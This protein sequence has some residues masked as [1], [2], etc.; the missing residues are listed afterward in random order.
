MY[1]AWIQDGLK[2]YLEQP[3]AVWHMPG[4]KRKPCFGGFLDSVYEY[5]VTEVP[6]TDDLYMPEGFIKKSLE[7]LRDIY[8]TKG[9]YYVVN[10]ATGG[11]FAAMAAC[12]N[13]GDTVLIARNCHKSVQNAA[14]VMQRKIQYVEPKWKSEQGSD[15]S[16]TKH[17]DG[18][19]C[20]NEVDEICRKQSGITAVV[21]TSPTYEGVIS[22]ISAIAEAAHRHHAYLI[23]DEAHGAHLP[24][25]N[26]EY[27]AIHLG[28]DI[29]VQ[30]LHKTLPAMTQTA[31]L[32]VQAES[33]CAEVEKNLEIFMSS[34][35]SYI[36]MMS[37]EAAVCYAATA[38][39]EAYKNNLA[40]FR[41][42]F[43]NRETG[44]G[45]LY[46]LKKE[47]VVTAGAYGMDE[48][49]LVFNTSAE[50]PKLMEWLARHHIVC[51]MAG[52]HHVVLI[53]TM[54]DT[55]EDFRF[56]QDAWMQVEQAFQGG[57][58]TGKKDI[59]VF[60]KLKAML[61]KTAERPIYVYPP[62]SYI[63]SA[64]EVITKEKLE[65]LLEYWN[66]G[67]FIRGI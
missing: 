5:D 61:D 38:D 8:K 19:I 16:F 54:K 55:K 52:R 39:W 4:H 32:H 67:I 63:V 41:S 48:T 45:T 7:Q 20:A 46:L 13:P 53:S 56:L 26:P 44:D 47:A 29:I 37:M 28:A 64:G 57:I 43:A 30:S 58:E 17:L 18:V 3:H 6:G 23:V 49:R 10:G 36:M 31:L 14:M 51:E 21:I 25:L 1:K 9:S 11:I 66:A 60:E 65:I 27:S 33:L 22:D 34:S 62:G 2:E 24:F 59:V 35:P 50:G 12:T 42:A 15:F 40:D